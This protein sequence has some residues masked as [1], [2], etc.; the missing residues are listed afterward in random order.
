MMWR[1]TLILNALLM[2]VLSLGSAASQIKLRNQYVQYPHVGKSLP[3]LPAISELALQVQ[4][5]LRAVPL[6]WAL[7][8]LA[9]LVLNW[10]KQ[11]PPRD[12][13][14]LHTSA[15]LLVGVFMLGFFVTAGVMPYINMV[16]GMAR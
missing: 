5:L 10:K 7:I 9:L 1:I 11:P 14:Q 6:A 13:V 12:L 2:G 16:V 4:W 3:S 8:T 15:T